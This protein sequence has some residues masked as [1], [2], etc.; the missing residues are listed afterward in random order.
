[1]AYLAHEQGRSDVADKLTQLITDALSR[2][3]A[4]ADGTPLIGTKAD[5]GL[6]PATSPGRAA[7]EKAISDGLLHVARTEQSG[8]TTRELY[9]ATEKGLQFLLEQVSPKQVLEDFVRALE[10]REGEVSDL[11]AAAH[12]MVDTL[13]GLKSAV[14]LVLPRVQSV[15]IPGLEIADRLVQTFEPRILPMTRSARVHAADEGESSSGGVAVLDAATRDSCELEAEN[16]SAALLA[17]LSDWSESATAGEDCPLPEL[18]RSLSCR[19]EPPS[20][21]EFHDCLRRLQAEHR[22]Y[23][24]P[25]TGPLYALPEPSFALLAGHNIAYYASIRQRPT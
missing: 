17:R 14:A 4:D 18:Y 22:I 21:G 11:V 5:P 10:R 13:S 1:M 2:A 24:H 15:R 9:A 19:H 6:F 12:R 23:L 16:L 8:K 3:A 25:W 20:I 7:S